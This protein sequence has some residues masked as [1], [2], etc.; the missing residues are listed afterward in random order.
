M[1][2]DLSEVTGLNW[3]TEPGQGPKNVSGPSHK[4]ED[5]MAGVL[6]VTCGQVWHPMKPPKH[7][8]NK[9]I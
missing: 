1:I 2:H 9:T 5:A 7:G 3:R 6:T 4:S 8:D